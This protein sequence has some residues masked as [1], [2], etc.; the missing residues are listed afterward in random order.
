MQ[1]KKVGAPR[2]QAG[3]PR[4]QAGAPRQQAGTPR[5][6][7]R[8]PRQQAKRDQRIDEFHR[9]CEMIHKHRQQKMLGRQ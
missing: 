8:V 1:I 2:Q 3:A 4:Q 7:A 5:Q 9:F 6:Q